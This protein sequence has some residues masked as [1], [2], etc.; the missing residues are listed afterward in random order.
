MEELYALIEQCGL[1]KVKG[2][3][4]PVSGGLMHKMFKVQTTTG[5]YAVKCLN[6]EIMNRPDAM[7]NY[8]E[9]EWLEWILE[10]N[11][12]SIVAALSFGDKKMISLGG[13]YY[14]VFHWNEGKI[15]DFNDISEKML[16]KDRE[17]AESEN[18][19]IEIVKG[20]M[21]DW[22][23]TEDGGYYKAVHKMPWCSKD[24]DDSD[25]IEYGHTME[26]YLGGL[27]KSGFVIN[28][29]K[30]CQR[31]D[32]TELMFMVKAKK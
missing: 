16:D 8:S 5:T 11:G 23:D 18:L 30:E 10:E 7:K 25:W 20:N 22:I 17:L 21:C 9:A 6:P 28:G 14:Y 4:L 3:I 1:G 13:R 26:E 29:Y 32:I 19:S 2:D 24:Y 31:E 27:L 15:T 12:I